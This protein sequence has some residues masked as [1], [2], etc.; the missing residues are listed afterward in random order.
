MYRIC[1]IDSNLTIFDLCDDISHLSG[2][3][4]VE[5]ALYLGKDFTILNP[6]GYVIATCFDSVLCWC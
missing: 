3:F 5:L 6:N 4:F 1:V 2:S